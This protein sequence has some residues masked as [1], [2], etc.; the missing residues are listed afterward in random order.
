MM[1]ED[2]KPARKSCMAESA[3]APKFRD[4]R[5]DFFRGLALLLI[6]ISHMPGNWLARY[7]PGAFGFSDSA[8]I[9]VFV[10][11]YAAS[12]AYG[13]IFRRV[14]FH[15]AAARIVKRFAELYTCNLVLLFT[16]AMLCAAGNRFLETGVDYIDLLNLTYFFEH[17]PEALMGFFA[18]RY[19]PNYFDI[20]TMYMV[21]IGMLPLYILLSR[22]HVT[23]PILASTSLYI[24]VPIFGWQLPAE[25]AFDRPWFFN[26]FAWQ[27]L[28]FTGFSF[29]SGWLKP[30][31]FRRWLTIIC[32]VFVVLSI[33][34][35][36]FPIYSHF[37]LLET[38]RD[39]LDP[40]VSKTNLGILRYLHFLCLTYLSIIFL[41]GRGH[42]LHAQALAPV[43]KA[44]QQ[45]LPV[46]LSGIAMSFL[47]GMALDLWGRTILKTLTVNFAG[48]GILVLTAYVVAWF[49]SQPWQAPP[50][51][52]ASS[53]H[54]GDRR[55][56]SNTQPVGRAQGNTDRGPFLSNRG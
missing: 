34:V 54:A 24:C 49:K 40:L 52:N 9:F 53:I 44:G 33:P 25:I 4:L 48:I 1:E 17:T 28:F 16:I 20:L 23:V 21:V 31:P 15:A 5:L 43:I 35:S 46:F 39:H 42:V 26:P 56:L 51:A 7:K 19:V 32:A 12:L 29:G 41:K 30:P 2:A 37:K 10:S 6:F 45:A 50:R 13:K 38:I 27:F 55:R 11:G 47:A 8:D 14:R 36:N 22:V 18:L 3:A